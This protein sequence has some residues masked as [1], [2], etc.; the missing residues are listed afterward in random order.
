MHVTFYCSAGKGGGARTARSSFSST[1]NLAPDAD[2]INLAAY[3][4]DFSM[5]IFH[6]Y[7]AVTRQ[8]SLSSSHIPHKCECIKG[9][10]SDA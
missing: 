10:S 2:G 1:A 4:A 6:P 8:P 7:G 5:S 3:F 9:H